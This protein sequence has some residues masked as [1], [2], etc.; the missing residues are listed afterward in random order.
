MRSSAV[1]QR[2]IEESIERT[3][4]LHADVSAETTRRGGLYQELS[5]AKER[6]REM[7]RHHVKR[8]VFKRGAVIRRKVHNGYVNIDEHFVVLGEPWVK[9]SKDGYEYNL[10]LVAKYDIKE[11]WQHRRIGKVD[12][13]HVEDIIG[14]HG[15]SSSYHVGAV[16]FND[17]SFK[18][19]PVVP[20][21]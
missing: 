13:A 3:K 12:T 18:Y 21:K 15:T 8:E 17:Y 11:R 9:T 16:D 20:G 7:E 19:T 5:D 4:A 14:Y 6:E 10:V 2:D 1:I